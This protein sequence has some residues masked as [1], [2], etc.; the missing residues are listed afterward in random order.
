MLRD[1]LVV[2]LRAIP[3]TWLSPLRHLYVRTP[4]DSLQHKLLSAILRVIHFRKPDPS[5]H[6]ITIADQP[7]VCLI[8][9]DSVIVRDVFWFGRR[10]Y[11]GIA[12]EWWETFCQEASGVLEIGANIGYYTVQGKKAAPK[13]R[14]LALEPQPRVARILRENIAL[15][16]LD[17][18]TV[19]E[20]AVVGKPGIETVDLVVRPEDTYGSPT[21]AFVVSHAR[22]IERPLRDRFPVK[23][24]PIR[25]LVE[26]VNLIKMDVEGHEPLLIEG[27]HDFLIGNKPTLFIEVLESA[28]RLKEQLRELCEVAGYRIYALMQD[29]LE[30]IDARNLPTISINKSYGTRD[31]LMTCSD[32]PT[33]GPE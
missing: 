3:L 32:L 29:R 10:G 13:V 21:D 11:E 6:H 1:I 9:C 25:D 14:Y 27:M 24:I 22:T 23:A 33:T 19:I 8:N 20:A 26:G 18:V 30:L 17:N 16:R 7:D 12:T 4:S 5:I 31:V 28:R 2:T 15:N